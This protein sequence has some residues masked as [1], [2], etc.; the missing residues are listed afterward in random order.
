LRFDKIGCFGA[1]RTIGSLALYANSCAE[2]E[3]HDALLRDLFEASK[4]LTD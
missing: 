4:A 1:V 3:Q 2:T